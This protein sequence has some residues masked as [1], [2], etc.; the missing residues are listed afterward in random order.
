MTG[1]TQTQFR[2]GTSSQNDS[3]TG[4]SGEATID[5]TNNRW[6][7]HDGAKAGGWS[8][9]NHKDVQNNAMKSG[10][11][12]GTANAI[13]LTLSPAPT[14]YATNM[15][16]V[17]TPTANNTGA[18]TINVN[19]LG[20]KTLKK[21]VSGTLTDLAS[22]D[23][24][25]GISYRAL[26]DG[27]Y[28]Q[29]RVD[30]SSGLTSVSQGNL[31]TSLGS[32]AAAGNAGTTAP[33]FDKPWLLGTM[34]G[35]EYAF[36]LEMKTNGSGGQNC[37]AMM[38]RQSA[39]TY[40]RQCFGVADLSGTITLTAQERYIT[41]SPPF[42]LGDGP[43]AGFIFARV[44]K[45]GDIVGTYIADVPP[46]AYNG[47]TKIRADFV[48]P[49]TGKKFRRVQKRP[50]TLD[51]IMS[52]A[53]E[54][55]YVLEEITQAIKNADMPL[56]PHPFQGLENPDEKIVLINPRDDQVTRILEHFN[57][58][59]HEEVTNALHNG[60]IYVDNEFL[61]GMKGPP[62]VAIAPLRYKYSR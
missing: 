11:I 32:V 47:P 50:F 23:L 10:T 48:H 29:V 44:N 45:A 42:D 17:F 15:E 13:T 19:S 25:S 51:Q 46:W 49:I 1:A 37:F 14:A 52:G 60:K 18:T 5:T 58:G 16:I 3:F 61:R 41:A 20:A 27:T 4:A 56:I 55:E 31:N 33:A 36:N 40:L 9:P 35:G 2:R 54:T 28:F 6:R 62:G 39:T 26:Y 53:P 8:V 57:N 59:G 30:Q 24:A 21:N 43:L 7:I 22:G 34:P 38:G 12:G